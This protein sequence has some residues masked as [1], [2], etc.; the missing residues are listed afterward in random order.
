MSKELFLDVR[1]QKAARAPSLTARLL[2]DHY[3]RST[4]SPVYT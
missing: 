4:E 3:I 2:P 1:M